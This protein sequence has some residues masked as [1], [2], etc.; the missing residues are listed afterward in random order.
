MR[1]GP[2]LL[3]L[4]ATLPCLAGVAG[5]QPAPPR[6]EP[7]AAKNAVDRRTGL[8]GVPVSVLLAASRRGDRAELG[9]TAERLGCARVGGLLASRDPDT[10]LA[11]LDAARALAGNARLMSAL[12]R[13]LAH[14]DGRVAER[15]ALVLGEVLR[16]DRPADLEAW[17]VPPDEV[18]SACAGLGRATDSSSASLPARLA[19]FDALAEAH[20]SCPKLPGLALASGDVWPEIRRA[21]LLAP[22]AAR[23][24]PATF[25]ADLT[26][27]PLPQVAGAA[28]AVFCRQRLPSL[29]AKGPEDSDKRRL[30][31]L[32]ALVL[33][34]ATP[35]EDAIEALPCLALSR[36]P[37]D[38]K[39]LETLRRRA[40]TPL[41]ARAAQLGTEAGK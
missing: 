17:D 3:T 16:S 24:L 9:R 33:A 8:A 34:E 27:D 6:P 25:V 13:L 14:A 23:T 19:A 15:A 2:A 31:R 36:D 4:L 38:R 1:R 32:R 7:A 18:T 30:S 10:L 41:G 12:T 26:A 11:A 37:E 35:A 40:G 5:A 22:Q 29:R 39:A 21:A 20:A 28:A